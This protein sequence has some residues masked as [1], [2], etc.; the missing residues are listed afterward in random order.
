[1]NTRNEAETMSVVRDA[2]VSVARW[3]AINCRAPLNDWLVAL[4]P[5]EV[6]TE[7]GD[8]RGASSRPRAARIGL[9]AGALVRGQLH[10]G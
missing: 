7:V 3:A 6:A 5:T 4:R 2:F 10:G 9:G 1:M 8:A